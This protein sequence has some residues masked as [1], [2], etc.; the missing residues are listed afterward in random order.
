MANLDHFDRAQI[1]HSSYAGLFEALWK[2]MEDF[3]IGY[4]VT[5][6]LLFVRN[7][8]FQSR[9]GKNQILN[10]LV[11]NLFVR[12]LRAKLLETKTEEQ[13]CKTSFNIVVAQAYAAASSLEF[14]NDLAGYLQ[15][16]GQNGE[17]IHAWHE[18]LRSV[19][20]AI[21]DECD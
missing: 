5:V 4:R 11:L 16:D 10:K 13:L 21:P 2:H 1:C 20:K 17:P 18:R 8:E 14:G 9:A 12:D 7:P 3:D 15:L 19:L 6:L